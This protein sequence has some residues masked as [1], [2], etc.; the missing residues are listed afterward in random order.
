MSLQFVLPDL[1]D[2]SIG[3]PPSTSV[4]QFNIILGTINTE[5]SQVLPAN[6]KGFILKSRG[7]SLLKI[8]YTVAESGTKFITVPKTGVFTDNNFYSS[9]TIFF[10]SPQTG[11]VVEIVA[12][13]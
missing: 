4:T 6:T 10:Q 13:V 3:T 7:L 11:D 12:Y 1:N 5:Q 9:Q 2:A 8:S